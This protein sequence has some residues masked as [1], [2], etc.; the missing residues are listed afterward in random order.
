[1]TSRIEN[2][3]KNVKS[4][5]LVQIVN[6]I[7]QFVV[8]T[9]FI[10][11]LNSE[12]LGINGL[13]T[14]ILTILSFAELGVGTA[15]VYSMYKPIAE[16]DIKKINGLMKLYKKFYTCI[17]VTI[18][19]LGLFVLP[20]LNKIVGPVH[21]VKESLVIIYI[22]F[23]TNSAS[24]YFFSYKKS[25]IIAHQKQ[26]IIDLFDS[27]FYIV[28][29]IVEVVA[30][31]VFR[32]FI[33]YIVIDI[34]ATFT[35]NICISKKADKLYPYLLNEE[36][37]DLSKK[38]KNKIFS[39]VKSLVIYKFGGVIMNGTDNILISYL[40][41]VSTVGLCSNYIM[42]INAIKSILSNALNGITASI[43]NL[44]AT[45]DKHK[46]EEIFYLLNFVYYLCFSF[47]G[48]AFVVLLNPFITFWLG[49]E[50]VLA[51]LIPF[52][53]SLSFF[54]EGIRTTSYTYRTT[55]GLFNKGKLTP[56]IGAIVNILLS[57]ILGKQMGVAGIFFATSIA[58]IVS[59][60]W[61]DPYLIYKYE[62][63]K[64]VFM[65][66]KKLI[67]YFLI[68]IVNAYITLRVCSF[69]T[70]GGILELILKGVA[71]CLCS[72]LINFICLFKTKELRNSIEYVKN[73]FI[74][75]GKK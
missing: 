33:V 61:I 1:M 10:K 3:I 66:Y 74:L 67:F 38:E 36:T 18:F 16:K 25:I 41:N 75:D 30:L 17:G 35:E 39:N 65:F 6:K 27:I 14:N 49:D 56:Y 70:F 29:S 58:Q 22:L 40:I 53:L 31:I 55:L 37:G 32:N 5:A 47:C 15:I 62:F 59:Y 21:Y 43:G 20:F 24:S 42:I 34:I 4:G 9:V 52:S 71:V 13:F 8:R 50:Y 60:C 73:H 54:V 68:F 72:S 19:V 2:S 64:N 44:N 26:N 46:K 57:I 12:Y 28:K 48:I 23:L 11:M 7:M 45:G 63:N 51:S 69:I